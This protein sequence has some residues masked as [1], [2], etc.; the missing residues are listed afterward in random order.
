M[1]TTIYIYMGK[2][3]QDVKGIIIGNRHGDQNLNLVLG[4]LHFTWC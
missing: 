2:G 3:T 4:C 1:L